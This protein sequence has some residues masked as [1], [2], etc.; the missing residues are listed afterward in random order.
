MFGFVY[1]DNNI[2]IES[3]EKYLSLNNSPSGLM[4]LS[5]GCTMFEISKYFSNGSLTVVDFNPEQIN[6]VKKKIYLIENL[7]NS[8][9]NAD[10]NSNSYDNFIEKINMDFDNLFV[11]IKNGEPF[12]EVF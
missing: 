7:Q 3:I 9:S 10:T 8:N 6:L 4:I 12:S 2:E 11:R 5:G 1:E